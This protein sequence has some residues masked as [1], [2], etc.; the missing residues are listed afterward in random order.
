M[1]AEIHICSLVV[2]ARHADTVADRLRPLPGLE[3]H[4]VAPGGKLV[5]VLEAD[6]E[7]EILDRIREIQGIDQVLAANL[8]Y[9]QSERVDALE[10]EIDED[11]AP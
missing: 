6:S 9:H 8:V 3:I 2:Y 11:H 7:A 4:A 10:E 5:V 1:S